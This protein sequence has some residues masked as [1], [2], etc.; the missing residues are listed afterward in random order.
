MGRCRHLCIPRCQG[1]ASIPRRAYWRFY[2]SMLKTLGERERSNWPY[3][4]VIMDAEC[5]GWRQI[6]EITIIQPLRCLKRKEDQKRSKEKLSYKLRIHM[7]PI[8]PSEIEHLIAP[9]I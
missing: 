4:T 7:Q 2:K 6:R 3:L 5:C 9:A 8:S 1:R